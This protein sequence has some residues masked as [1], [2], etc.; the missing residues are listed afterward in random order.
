[1]DPSVSDQASVQAMPPPPNPAPRK[2][3]LSEG[4]GML[5]DGGGA[6][7]RKRAHPRPSSSSTKTDLFLA[8]AHRIKLKDLTRVLTLSEDYYVTGSVM[9][10]RQ[11]SEDSQRVTM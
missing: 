1:M 11:Y 9:G 3:P 5:S 7:A 8:S 2:R 10:V 6:E 4:S